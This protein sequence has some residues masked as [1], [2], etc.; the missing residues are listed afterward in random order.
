MRKSFSRCAMLNASTFLV[1]VYENKE[2][3]AVKFG[4]ENPVWKLS[5]I[6]AGNTI[7]PDAIASDT[8]G[9]IHI[10]DGGNNRIL[11][12]HGLTGDVFV[13]GCTEPGT[14]HEQEMPFKMSHKQWNLFYI[15]VYCPWHK[16]CTLQFIKPSEHSM[17]EPKSNSVLRGQKPPLNYNDK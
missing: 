12:T 14:S 9:N 6:V 10:S 3:K 4:S 1:L 17:W 2:I 11:K 15:T 8:E 13:T 5:P 7:Q 16:Q